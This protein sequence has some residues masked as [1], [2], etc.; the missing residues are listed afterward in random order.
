MAYVL[1][2]KAEE[3]VI[4]IFVEGVHSFGLHQAER[5]HSQLEKCF[6]F[7]ADNPTAAPQRTE[8]TPPVRIHPSGS[9]L[10]IYRIEPDNEVFIIRVRHERE[11]WVASTPGT[12]R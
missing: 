10:V 1:S 11:D 7:L 5:Y 2:R 8:I 6:Q 12:E 4:N 3:D 9:H